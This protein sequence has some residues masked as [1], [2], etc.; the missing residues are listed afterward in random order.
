MHP[1]LIGMFVFACT[2]GGALLGIGLRARLPAHHLDAE[3]RDTVNHGIGLIAT[4]AAL[5]LG[6]VTA[7]AK[8]SFDGVDAAVKQTAVEILSLDRVLARY[9]PEASE[10]RRGLKVAVLNRIERTWPEKSSQAANLDP[11]EAQAGSG[12]EALANAIDGLKPRDDTERALQ[13]RAVEL[14]EALLQARWLIH[15]GS[16]TSVPWPFLMIL[17]FWLTAIFVSFGLFAP[18]NGTVLAVLFVCAVSVGSS[19]FLVLEMDAPFEGLLRVSSDPM[20]FAYEHL[21]E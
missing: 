7:S 8:S 19:V 11:I 9:G 5:V 3:S 14:T 1:A 12:P 4:M 2:F 13:S 6:L 17:L 20:R 18:R 15:G 10:I 16:P 21:G